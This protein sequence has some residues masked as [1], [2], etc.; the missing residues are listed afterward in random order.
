MRARSSTPY[1]SRCERSSTLGT[2]DDNAAYAALDEAIICAHDKGDIPGLITAFDYGIQVWASFGAHRVAA[3][4]GGVVGGP[5]GAFGSLPIYEV[6]NREHALQEARTALGD[7]GVPGNHRRR[8]GY[9][10]GRG[11]RV[12]ARDG[13]LS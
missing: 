5:Y 10:V 2:D 1:C 3:T 13:T 4:V 7:H 6:P 12:R 8:R 9:V 11:R